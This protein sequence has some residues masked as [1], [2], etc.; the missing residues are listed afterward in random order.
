MEYNKK[1]YS[2]IKKINDID[3]YNKY[4]EDASALEN[5]YEKF[6]LEKSINDLIDAKIAAANQNGVSSSGGPGGPPFSWFNKNS[7]RTPNGEPMEPTFEESP[8]GRSAP[9]V[10]L[11]AGEVVAAEGVAALTAASV[12]ATAA[13]VVAA[14]LLGVEAYNNTFK[15]TNSGESDVVKNQNILSWLNG[16]KPGYIRGPDGKYRPPASKGVSSGV[17]GEGPRGRDHYHPNLKVS[18]NNS[19]YGS[20]GQTTQ[21]AYLGNDADLFDRHGGPIV[22]NTSIYQ[23]HIDEVANSGSFAVVKDYKESFRAFSINSQS[24]LVE[25]MSLDI[26]TS[27][28]MKFTAKTDIVITSAQSITL[29]APFIII[30]GNVTSTG[31]GGSGGIGGSGGQTYSR[32]NQG[33]GYDQQNNNSDSGTSPRTFQM[34]EPTQ[35]GGGPVNTTNGVGSTDSVGSTGSGD[36]GSWW[37]AD[38]QKYAVNYLMKNSGLSQYGAA[39][40]VAR[41]T[42]EAGD[43]P[44]SVNKRSGAF[45]IGQW[46]GS[47]KKD[48]LGNTNFDDQLAHAVTELNSTEKRAANLLRKSSSSMEASMG[49][50]AYERAEGYNADTNNDILTH[51][52][53]V[54]AVY[55]N[56]FGDKPTAANM[57]TDGGSTGVSSTGS[58]GSIPVITGK[59]LTP[60][61][62]TIATSDGAN[63]IVRKGTNMAGVNPML[64]AV[65]GEAIKDLPK[66][67]TVEAIS[68]LDGRANTHNHPNGLAIDYVIYDEH[69]NPIPND[70]VSTGAKYYEMLA[71]SMRIHGNKMYPHEK[72]AWGGTWT[73]KGAPP[74]G[75]LMHYQ[76]VKNIAHSAQNGPAEIPGLMSPQE[77]STYRNS[78][79]A[80]M[81]AP[82]QTATTTPTPIKPTTIATNPPAPPHTSPSVTANDSS[83]KIGD[84]IMASVKN[85]KPKKKAR[86]G[87]LAAGSAQVASKKNT[88]THDGKNMSATWLVLHAGTQLA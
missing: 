10:E 8:I 32:P 15:Q 40:L 84:S 82:V 42:T 39:G 51:S 77:L 46:L 74:G 5:Q 11:G 47:R 31:T 85:R 38:R 66:G 19:I 3:T 2:A 61:G 35:G 83:T 13:L 71:Q 62:S 76:I 49:A 1:I 86:G 21:V 72:F 75:D 80:R 88:N 78:V 44:S 36:K 69:H 65:M 6:K 56:A 33:G 14:G 73:G 29:D 52:T 20:Y 16:Y 70:R 7:P 64:K 55:G 45:G 34:S 18:Q 30:G 24:F 23:S 43:G 81:N 57:P 59:P 54:D 37:T 28:S 9:L 67:F 79:I 87:S 63:Y 48:I 17:S 4:K 68:G 50:T 22:S 26:S 12:A 53:P 60:G 41:W 58:T 25:T 27:Q